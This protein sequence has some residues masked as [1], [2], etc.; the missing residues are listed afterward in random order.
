MH[1]GNNANTTFNFYDLTAKVNYN[2]NQNNTVFLSGYFG[3]DVF[4]NEF[5]FNWGNSTLSAR[6]NHVF[7]SKLFLNSTAFYSNYDYLLDSDLNN[8]RPNNQFRWTSNIQNLSFSAFSSIP[9]PLP[10]LAEQ[11]RIAAILDKADRLRRRRSSVVVC[12]R[13]CA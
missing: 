1:P 10:N 2:I 6:W 12:D 13:Q 11:K 8:K 5:G 9:I 4:G 3:R 7:S